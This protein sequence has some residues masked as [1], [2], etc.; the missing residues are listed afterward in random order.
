METF[1][2]FRVNMSK[3]FSFFLYGTSRYSH[4]SDKCKH[5]TNM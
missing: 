1:N 3:Y 4:A 2:I 5:V